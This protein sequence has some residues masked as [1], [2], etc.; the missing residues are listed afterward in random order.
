ME[1][2][3][4]MIKQ[5]ARPTGRLGRI[6]GEEM[7]KCHYELW[8]WGLNQ[9]SLDNNMTILDVGC[10]GGAAIKLINSLTPDSRIHGIDISRDMVALSREVNHASERGSLVE[11][12]LGA[13]DGAREGGDLKAVVGI[14]LG[15]R[16]PPGRRDRPGHR[17]RVGKTG[18]AEILDQAGALV[19]SAA[20]PDNRAR[21]R[22]GVSAGWDRAQGRPA[23]CGSIG[24]VQP[25]A[26]RCRCARF[27]GGTGRKGRSGVR[28][29]DRAGKGATRGK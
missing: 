28:F 4:D 10:G 27:R 5:C 29:S 14:K 7:N 23:W 21:G 20:R 6:V 19:R 13:V 15:H 12:K 2:T 24:P 1:W 16:S 22:L 8:Q 9:I 18:A 17:R 11:I 25:L 3:E 26:D